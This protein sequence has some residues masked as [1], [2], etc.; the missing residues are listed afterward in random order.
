MH[1]T[2]DQCKRPSVKRELY[3]KGLASRPYAILKPDY[4]CWQHE[5]IACTPGAAYPGIARYWMYM[6]PQKAH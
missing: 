4:F 1:Y 6:K 3:P 5:K 2:R